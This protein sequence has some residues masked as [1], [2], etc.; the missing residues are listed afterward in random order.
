MLLRYIINHHILQLN[1]RKGVQTVWYTKMRETHL[2]HVPTENIWFPSQTSVSL[3]R[4]PRPPRKH[5]RFADMWFIQYVGAVDRAIIQHRRVLKPLNSVDAPGDS[6]KNRHLRP[7]LLVEV[8]FLF[9]LCKTHVHSPLCNVT[10]NHEPID[11][12]GYLVCA[13]FFSCS[14]SNLVAAVLIYL[15]FLGVWSVLCCQHQESVNVA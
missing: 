5:T 14:K 3:S 7:S 1:G 6:Q 9:C 11:A 10:Q 15:F 4:K 12:H 13:L 8:A 2:V